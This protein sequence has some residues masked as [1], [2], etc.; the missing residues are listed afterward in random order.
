MRWTI[1]FLPLFPPSFQLFRLHVLPPLP[2][3]PQIRTASAFVCPDPFAPVS[4]G[5]RNASL[6]AGTE[7]AFSPAF[8]HLFRCLPNSLN[9]PDLR[10]ADGI[11]CKINLIWLTI[12]AAEFMKS[13]YQLHI[14]AH[15]TVV[16]SAYG[17]HCFFSNNPK[18]PDMIM[19]ALTLSNRI[20]AARKERAYSRDCILAIIFLGSL[21]FIT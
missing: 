10:P 7:T 15:C 5:L 13:D 20:R 6:S 14:L 9:F 4:C 3:G 16:I 8:C 2:D 17:N 11:L 1:P 19:F 18:A 21:Y 12:H